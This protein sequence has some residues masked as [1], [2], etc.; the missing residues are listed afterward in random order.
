MRSLYIYF[1]MTGVYACIFNGKPHKNGEVWIENDAFEM[2]C[3]MESSRSWRTEVLGCVLPD[4]TV[5][6]IDSQMD[7]GDIT[8]KCEKH[9][10]GQYVR[11]RM[12][13]EKSSC[14]GHPYESDWEEDFLKFKCDR[15]GIKRF[16]GCVIS[17]ATLIEDGEVKT[18]DGDEMECKKH[19]NGTITL[20][21]LGKV[22]NATCMDSKGRLSLQ[23]EE[24][25]E[26]K[27]ARKRCTQGGK[28]EIN[29]CLAPQPYTIKSM[30]QL[31]DTTKKNL[32]NFI[33]FVQS[34]LETA[35]QSAIEIFREYI[36]TTERQWTTCGKDLI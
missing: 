4:E 26:G 15:G 14:N 30:L 27:F 12:K 8:W 25:I 10:D 13:N 32:N 18:V 22:K 28:V 36:R 31:N 34:K 7:I 23:G 20:K 35:N 16:M 24:W 3:I 2:K 21:S 1:Y 19:K 6:T 5:L 9:I 29:E 33:R 11:R 17:L